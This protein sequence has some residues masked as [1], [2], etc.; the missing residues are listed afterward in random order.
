MF[1]ENYKVLQWVVVIVLV[2]AT[3]AWIFVRKPSQ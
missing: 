2:G 3:L 1:F